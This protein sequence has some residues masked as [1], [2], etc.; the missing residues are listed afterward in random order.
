VKELFGELSYFKIKRVPRA[1]NQQADA[2]AKLASSSLNSLSKS[3][4]VETF[5]CRSIEDE[6]VMNIEA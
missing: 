1:E 3:I 5:P 4:L 2:L 6:W